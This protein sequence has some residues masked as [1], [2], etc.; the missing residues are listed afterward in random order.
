[1]TGLPAVNPEAKGEG[2]RA[3]A[4][5]QRQ[6]K[7][8]GA[9]EA[10]GSV[11]NVRPV[12]CRVCPPVIPPGADEGQQP[13]NT[14]DTMKATIYDNTGT[15]TLLLDT[16]TFDSASIDG[17]T[18]IF[19]IA[20]KGQRCLALGILLEHDCSPEKEGEQITVDWSANDWT[21]RITE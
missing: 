21:L 18:V 11:A 14:L 13:R 10:A 9:L 7:H 15:E 17:A 3:K 12:R 16:F 5:R 8:G 6:S 20:D 1:M 19:T 4:G 2:P